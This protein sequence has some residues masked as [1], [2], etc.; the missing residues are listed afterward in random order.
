MMC[1]EIFPLGHLVVTEGR[2]FVRCNLSGMVHQGSFLLRCRCKRKTT[3]WCSSRKSG[4]AMVHGRK[5]S[6]LAKAAAGPPTTRATN[7]RGAVRF[8]STT[9]FFTYPHK[10]PGQNTIEKEV[11]WQRPQ[12]GHPRQVHQPPVHS[13]Q[14]PVHSQWSKTA[15]SQQPMV[16]IPTSSPR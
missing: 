4:K 15:N 10:F 16:L 12:R 7:I 11:G 5:R 14:P 13:S 9:Q 1:R 6:G 8:E 2:A 3:I